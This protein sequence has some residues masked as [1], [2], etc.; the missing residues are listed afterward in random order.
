MD[1]FGIGDLASRRFPTLSSGEQRLALLVR[2][3]IKRPQLL[4]LDEPLHGL[5]ASHK[6]LAL[7]AIEQIAAND[8]TTLVY[9]THYESEIPKCV[10]KRKIL[11]KIRNNQ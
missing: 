1:A 3:L 10:D 8:A 11:K 2:T 4:I 9:V 6:A 7:Q 5:D